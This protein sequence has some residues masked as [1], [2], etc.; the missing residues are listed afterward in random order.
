MLFIGTTELNIDAKGRLA[1]PARYRS[2]FPEGESLRW[3]SMAWPNGSIR[4]YPFKTFLELSSEWTVTLIQS[5]DAAELRTRLFSQSQDV[6]QDS[7]GRIRVP[8]E[9]LTST[10]LGTEVVL[11]GAGAYLEIRD[12]ATWL[13]DGP[14]RFG[15]LPDLIARF[16]RS[17]AP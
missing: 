3:V 8:Q 15:E 6:E 11:L 10:G 4:L 13:A 12:R 14:K 16:T 7:A 17:A 9:H 2:Q 1:I 5:E